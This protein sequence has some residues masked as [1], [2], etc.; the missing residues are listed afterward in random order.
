[1]ASQISRS[2]PYWEC[3]VKDIYFGKPAYKNVN[4]LKQAVF[5]YW[6]RIPDEVINKLIDS[7]P[8]RMHKVVE[9]KGK[10]LAY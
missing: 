8:R 4:E 10:S 2:Y 5:D 1:M 9:M 7:M 6:A 3:M